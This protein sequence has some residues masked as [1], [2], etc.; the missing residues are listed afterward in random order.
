MCI[1]LCQNVPVFGASSAKMKC[2][3]GF[4]HFSARSCSLGRVAM[5]CKTG[6]HG[7]VS[8]LIVKAKC[9]HRRSHFVC[10]SEM[11]ANIDPKQFQQY[12]LW[13]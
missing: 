7:K 2:G 10:T 9:P 5:V 8:T 13:C 1:L 6:V 3:L 4:P 12:F 11:Y